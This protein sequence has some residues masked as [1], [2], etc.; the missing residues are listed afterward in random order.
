MIKNNIFSIIIALSILYLS[1]ASSETLDKVAV[2]KFEGLDKLV[3]IIMYF[4]LMMSIIFE[5]RKQLSGIGLLFLI[6]IIPFTFGAV[7][8]IC[9]PLFTKTRSASIYD[10]LFNLMGILLAVV[11]FLLLRKYRTKKIR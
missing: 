5:H 2:V 10:A 3:H 11:L 4:T 1:F 8:E 7:I 6:A 9:Q